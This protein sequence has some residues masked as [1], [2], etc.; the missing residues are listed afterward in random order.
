[1]GSIS[2]SQYSDF[3]S[4]VVAGLAFYTPKQR[5][6][7][8]TAILD[9]KNGVTEKSV[10]PAFRPISIRSL[11][12]QNRIW[13]APMCMYSCQDGMFSDFHVAH[14][15]QW[16]M[17]GSALIHLEA[18]AVTARGRNTP[19]D[20]GIWSDNHIA[21][22]KRIVDLIHSQSQKVAIQLQHAGRKGSVT[23]PW[24]GLRLVPD[25]FDGYANQVQGPTAE[26]WNENYA[27]P[28]EMSED[29]IL[30]TIEAYGQAARRA[31]EAG[32][33]VIAVHG[34]HGYLLHSFASPATN[35]RQ[36]QWGGSFENRTRIGVEIIRAIRRNIPEDMPVFWKISAVDWLPKG[37]GWELED[38]LRYIPILAAEGVDLFDVSSGGTDRRQQVQLGQQYQ[39]PFAKAVKDLKLPNVFVAAVG[40]IRD[41]DTVHDILSNGKADV[42]HVAREFLRDPN[43]VQRVALAT[44]TEVTWVDQYHRAPM[45]RKYVEST[46]TIT[47]DAKVSKD[48]IRS[49]DDQVSNKLASK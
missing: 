1:M 48:V 10:A 16:A 19:Q 33:D 28:G 20:A 25:E 21:P 32:V 23:P 41:A 46:T 11:T 49:H 34:A 12:F 13:V 43:F 38:T 44:G 31:V 37:E 42:V 47:T 2:E 5:V 17:R 39:V 14:Y 6:P 30:E 27:T 40:W 29:E 8:G 18:T 15:G 26:P 4:E 3:R 22:L 36:D 9:P 7:V 45:N 35:K 24:L